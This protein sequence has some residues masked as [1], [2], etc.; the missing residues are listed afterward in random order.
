MRTLRYSSLAK[1][2]VAD[3]ARYIATSA[4]N[5][6]AGDK[7]AQALKEQCVKLATLPGQLGRIR[8]DL[9]LN[10]RSFPFCGYVLVFRYVDGGI[11]ILRVLHGHRDVIAYFGDDAQD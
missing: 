3:I 11:D 9:G 7:F 10:I 6:A 4:S 1:R 2:D 5:R 8:A